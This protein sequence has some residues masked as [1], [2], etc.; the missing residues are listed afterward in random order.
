MSTLAIIIAGCQGTRL[1][2]LS[3]NRAKA[4]L[5][6]AGKYRVIDFVLSNCTNSEIHNVGILTQYHPHALCDH[7]GT[8]QPWD[9]DRRW[10][11]GIALLMPYQRHGRFLNWYN[12]TADAVF[13]NLDFVVEQDV[14]TVLVLP[15]EQVYKMDYGALLRYHLEHQA[16]VTICGTNVSL[17]PTSLFDLV[18]AD[19]DGRVTGF[20]ELPAEHPNLYASMG[21]YVFRT[22]VL[23][24]RLA[25]DAALQDSLHDF[26]RDVL[27]RMHTLGDRLCI[28]PFGGYW[29][30]LDTVETYWEANMDLLHAVPPLNLQDRNW[31]I[32]TR[33]EERPP[34]SIVAGA[35]ISNSLITDGCMVQGRVENSVLSP[36]VR[37]D[38]GALVRD[39][40]VFA[41]C[42]IGSNAI[43]DRAILDSNVIVGPG[44]Y[45]GTG[46][47]TVPHRRN[48]GRPQA[49]ITLVA[50]ETHLPAG[51]YL[52]PKDGTR[53]DLAGDS[54][55]S[56]A[57]D[58]PSWAGVRP[59]EKKPDHRLLPSVEPA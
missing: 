57:I 7:I 18:S 23:I 46:N 31:S 41:D 48:G 4:A 29:A 28:Y 2:V 52:A 59:A 21:I 38:A 50:Q 8:G 27:P 12:G 45:V 42:E 3:E 55:F 37:V 13:K 26:G 24:D 5:P 40:V 44:E 36:G 1:D 54:R 58:D 30:N 11:G 9:L 47:D 53:S 34:V 49:G 56:G 22:D 33:N 39:S 32:Y 15:G 19:G 10:S 17:G 6:F 51:Y 16:D 35:S 43:V 25:Q 20:G 14:D